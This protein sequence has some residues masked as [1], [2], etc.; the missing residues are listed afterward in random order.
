MAFS[1]QRKQGY[2]LQ[3]NI[4]EICAELRELIDKNQRQGTVSNS[5]MQKINFISCT[6]FMPGSKRKWKRES[7]QQLQAE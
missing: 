4:E 7:I 1:G 3:N 2:V 6:L 5:L